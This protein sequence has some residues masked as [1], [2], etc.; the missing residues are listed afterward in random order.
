[1]RTLES[2]KTFC[3]KCRAAR[4]RFSKHR[5]WV[6]TPQTHLLGVAIRS[7]KT[8]KGK[9]GYHEKKNRKNQVLADR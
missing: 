5:V 6:Y 3:Q 7:P 2:K 4:H 8:P 1:M 9:D